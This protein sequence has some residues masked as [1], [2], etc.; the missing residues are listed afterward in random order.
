MDRL[1][2]EVEGF[3]TR[4][5]LA[6]ERWT[7]VVTDAADRGPVA[8][9]GAGSKAVSLLNLPSIAPAISEVVDVI[10]RKHGLHIPRTGHRIE[11]PEHLRAVRPATVLVANGVYEGEVRRALDALGVAPEV[12]CP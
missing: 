8:L 11:P 5:E 2:E 10:V 7:E 4:R 1:L 9:W 3:A 6:V 12:I